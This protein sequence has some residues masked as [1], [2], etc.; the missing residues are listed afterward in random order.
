[1]IQ[2][3]FNVHTEIGQLWQSRRR[4]ARFYLVVSEQFKPR[5]DVKVILVNTLGPEGHQARS[6]NFLRKHCELLR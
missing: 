2:M 5:E 3:N 1:M 4:K 6:T